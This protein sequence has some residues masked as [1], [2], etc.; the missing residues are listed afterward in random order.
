[1]LLKKLAYRGFVLLNNMDKLKY[2]ASKNITWDEYLEIKQIVEYYNIV[3]LSGHKQDGYLFDCETPLDLSNT[4][5]RHVVFE[6]KGGAIFGRGNI[7]KEKNSEI[8]I[9]MDDFEMY[10]MLIIKYGKKVNKL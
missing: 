6:I 4:G 8:Q 10:K 5:P 7:S 1:M 2:I 3:Y 9:I